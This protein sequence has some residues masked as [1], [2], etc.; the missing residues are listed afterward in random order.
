MADDRLFVAARSPRCCA[1][2]ILGVAV[3]AVAG[4]RGPTTEDYE[5]RIARL[6]QVIQE[7]GH[8][9]AARQATI[10]IQN[11]QIEDMRQLPPSWREHIFYPERLLID[12]LSGGEDYDGQPGDDG[13][14]VYLKPLD[15]A[16]DIVKVA[17]DIRI[18]LFD[19]ANPPRRNLIGEYNF[20]VD[21]VGKFWHGKLMTYHYTL[22]CP[23]RH[24]PPEHREITIR[25]T[26]VDYLT[27]RVMTAQTTCT[28]RPPP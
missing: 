21:E 5:R 24:G 16:G 20:G 13:V 19:L 6:E 26:F 28:V 22:K 11:Q 2:L 7:N 27:K 1:A 8:E 9:L 23:W 12:G 3:L 15:K 18:Q 14:T 17:G 4:C 25:A 10:D